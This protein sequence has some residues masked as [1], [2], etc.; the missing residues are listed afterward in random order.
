MGTNAQ[1]CG[2]IQGT[3]PVFS[4]LEMG[5]HSQVSS[6]TASAVVG[7]FRLADIRADPGAGREDGHVIIAPPSGLHGGAGFEAP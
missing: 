3:P 2:Q 6:A 5:H 4:W 7:G 1:L